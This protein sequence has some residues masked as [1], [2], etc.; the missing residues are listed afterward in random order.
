MELRQ[1]RYFV[2]IAELGSLSRASRV[3]HI[4]QPALSQQ[5]AHL[6]AELGQVLLT[7]LSSGVRMTE[8]GEV[9]LH[10]ARRVLRLID[11][12][13]AAVA[14]LEKK[15]TGTVRVGLPQSTA[16]HYALLLENAVRRRYSEVRLELFDEISSHIP[17]HLESGRIDLGV[18]VNDEDEP[19]VSAS[20]LMDEQLF[21]VSRAGHAPGADGVTA[22]QL[23]RLPLTI[24]AS[25]LGVRP[26]VDAFLAREGLVLPELLVSANSMN[27]MRGA[28]LCGQAHGVMPWAA[29]AQELRSGTLVALP[30]VP[31]L[32]RRVY[33]CTAR[34]A[35]LSLAAQA[36]HGLLA[37]TVTE[38]VQ[39]G[40]WP[41]A[42]LVPSPDHRVP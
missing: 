14:S 22:A 32:S 13:P 4:A 29:V 25:G 40:S 35:V 39:N 16:A 31:R 6:E 20:P 33:L 38:L 41:G 15:P 18:I 34:N 28:M 42:T 36:V 17:A 30:I 3:L 26:I 9:F 5:M 19:L 7:R 37:D 1:L 2:R 21:L 24:P 27:L 11:D 10:H 12:I 8:Q 23:A